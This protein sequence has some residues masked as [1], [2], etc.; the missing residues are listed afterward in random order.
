[1]D[2]SEERAFRI[3][4][5]MSMAQGIKVRRGIKVTRDP[6]TI[7]LLLRAAAVEEV[8]GT[9][10]LAL[11]LRTEELARAQDE[12]DAKQEQARGASAPPPP[13]P[14]PAVPPT[15]DEAR[16]LP[17]VGAP[18]SVAELAP[19]ARE[20]DPEPQPDPGPDPEPDW[21]YMTV[22]QLRVW[23][24]HATGE[25]PL[26]SARKKELDLACRRLWH[27]GRRPPEPKPQQTREDSHADGPATLTQVHD[28]TV[29]LSDARGKTVSQASKDTAEAEGPTVPTASTPPEPNAPLFMD[30]TGPSPAE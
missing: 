3:P 22:T 12:F 27:E 16:G 20:P 28:D 9:E 1:M 30:A 11:H 21:P 24:G 6:N 29:H 10:E 8:T 18:L 13:P 26:N 4:W 5:N 2:D 25:R 17:A 23:I 15:L 14:R 19:P 7:R